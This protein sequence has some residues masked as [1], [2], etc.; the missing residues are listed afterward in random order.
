MVLYNIFKYKKKISIVILFLIN[1]I[2]SLQ[3]FYYYNTPKKIKEPRLDLPWLTSFE[4]TTHYS[5]AKKGYNINKDKTNLF[6][7]HGTH[8]I[9][10]FIDGICKNFNDDNDLLLMQLNLL[11]GNQNFARLSIDGLATI[12][13]LMFT[14]TQNFVKGF[15]LELIMPFTFFT[16]KD[17][18]FNDLSAEELHPNNQ[19][20]LW[21]KCKKNLNP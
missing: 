7:V 17:L 21:L 15:F 13:E 20:P 18:N 4:F 6:D 5:Q 12:T 9:P 8:Y 2:Y 3:T 16:I 19:H 10:A 14:Y 11:P 1:H